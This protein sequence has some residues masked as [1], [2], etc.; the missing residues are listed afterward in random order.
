MRYLVGW[1]ITD[2]DEQAIA[3]LPATAWTDSLDQDGRLQPGYHVA[4]LTGAARGRG[5]GQ[6]R[7]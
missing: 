1:T 3:R 7:G 6:L 4:E 5:S 2:L